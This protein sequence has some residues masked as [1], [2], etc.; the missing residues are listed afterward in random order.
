[1]LDAEFAAFLRKYVGLQL[2]AVAPSLSGVSDIDETCLRVAIERTNHC[3][4]RIKGFEGPRFNHL[5]SGQYAT[6]L[7][8]LAHQLGASADKT[9]A[10]RVFLLNKALNGIDLYYEVQMPDVFLI[11]H[12]V[13]MV[14]A[15]AAYGSGCIFHQ[16]CTVG[17]NQNDR[18][19]LGPGIIMYP[20][21]SIIGR[22][23][24][25]EN[26]VLSPGVQLINTDTPG[27]C[28]VFPGEAGRPVFKPISEYYA[29]RY[30]KR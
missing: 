17:R 6:F 8:Y 5:N 18:P 20:H 27:D 19:L 30:L 4:S 12:T 9:D 24:V 21:S 29:D 26:T 28:L 23:H 14:F 7:Y 3:T 10:A 13:G 1:M 11:G 22:C 2:Q 25:R 15:K 16:G